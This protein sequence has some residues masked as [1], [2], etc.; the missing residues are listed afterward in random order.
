MNRVR[1]TS[2]FISTGVLLAA[3]SGTS[4]AHVGVGPTSNFG[5]GLLHPLG[6]I[7]HI[8]AMVAVGIWA[9]Q[10]GGRALW[11]VPLA[12]VAMMTVGGALGMAGVSLP[13]AERGI[14]LSLLVLGV[15][16]AA[17]VRLPLLAGALTVGAFALFHGHSHGAEM[18]LSVSGVEYA[19]GFVVATAFLHGCGIALVVGSRRLIPVRASSVVL[20]AAGVFIALAGVYLWQV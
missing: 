14:L 3:W 20:R 15:L 12:F 9:A 6:G 4:F 16:V 17:W 1:T 2:V 10:Q 19:V 13:F 11:A 18:P 8:L 5:A 7:D